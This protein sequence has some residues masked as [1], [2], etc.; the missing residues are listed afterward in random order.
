MEKQELHVNFIEKLYCEGCQKDFD[1]MNLGYNPHNYPCTT[2]WKD[3]FLSFLQ[4][5]GFI[6]IG[7]PLMIVLVPLIVFIII[8]DRLRVDT[9]R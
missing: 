5:C 6:I 7:I 1:R 3:K 9:E 8:W 4:I 2:P